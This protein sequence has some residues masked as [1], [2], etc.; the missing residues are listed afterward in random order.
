MFLKMVYNVFFYFI[1]RGFEISNL[2]ILLI[3]GREV[4]LNHELVDYII[5]NICKIYDK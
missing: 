3:L 2:R 1:N 4:T 5:L